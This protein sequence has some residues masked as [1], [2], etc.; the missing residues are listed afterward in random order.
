MKPSFQEMTFLEKKFVCKIWTRWTR[1]RTLVN[2][3]LGNKIIVVYYSVVLN[4]LIAKW[5]RGNHAVG[6][7]CAVGTSA[8][9]R[10][11]NPNFGFTM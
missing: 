3:V 8:I 9:L 5:S 4:N 11:G 2:V 10:R 6:T 7:A 1:K